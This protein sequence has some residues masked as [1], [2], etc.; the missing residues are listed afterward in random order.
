[1][2]PVSSDASLALAHVHV[3]RLSAD[4]SFVYFDFA[5]ELRAEE[6]ILHRK[7]NSL[8][9]EP[10]RLLGNSHVFSNLVTAHAVLA[11]GEHPR[12]RK[13]FIQRNRA[14]LIDRSDFDGELALGVMT[15]ALP[16]AP[17]CIEANLRGSA[18]GTDYAVR[19]SADS[20]VV[21]AVVR[22]REVD[23][24]FLKALWFLAHLRSPVTKIYQNQWASQVYFCLSLVV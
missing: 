7:A 22:I 12:C 21:N 20:D 16:S 6:I 11:V 17:L 19:P 5:A 8:K 1:M 2:V 24:R 3:P 15:A 9:H 18:T 14:V 13:P 23:N 10:C 4:E